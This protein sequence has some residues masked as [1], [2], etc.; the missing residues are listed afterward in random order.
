MAYIVP[1][2]RYGALIYHNNPEKYKKKTN[3]PLDVMQRMMNQTCKQMYDLPKC[4]ANSIV[5]KIMGNWN[6]ETLSLMSYSRAVRVW[7]TI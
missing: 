3:A 4:A 6:M 7:T 1:H 5:T 2:F